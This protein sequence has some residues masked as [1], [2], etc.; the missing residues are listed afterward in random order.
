MIITDVSLRGHLF[1]AVFFGNVTYRC[2]P[3]ENWVAMPPRISRRQLASAKGGRINGAEWGGYGEGC[4]LPSWLGGLGIVMSSLSGL[5]NGAP[6]RNTVG[7][8][9]SPLNAF[10]TY[11]P[12]LWVCQTVFHVTFGGHAKV[13]GQL[14]LLPHLRTTHG[15]L[16]LYVRSTDNIYA[17]SCHVVLDYTLVFLDWFF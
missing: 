6:A 7:I 2:S 13:W 3:G 16:S 9:W 17:L 1:T 5:W 8:F 15:N 12:M 4:P 11:M 14:P 10:C